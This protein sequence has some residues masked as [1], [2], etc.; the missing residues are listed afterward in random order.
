MVSVDDYSHEK[1][2][3]MPLIEI[4]KVVML[5]EKKAMKFSEAF[6]KAA[7]LKGLSDDE[8]QSKISQFYTDLNVDG[9]FVSNGSNTWG[10]KQWYRE[11]Q[12]AVEAVQSLPKVKR[13]KKKSS[14]Q[15]FLDN[16]FEQIDIN[17]DEIELDYE[18]E[19]DFEFEFDED[20]DE[21]FEDTF[22]E[23]EED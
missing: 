12:T 20:F 2:A 15:E 4:A 3:K 6:G 5:Q 17:I 13:K 22:E 11:E 21:E 14:N 19:E 18:D 7:D 23:K 10:L 8:R 9:S 16:E 1:M